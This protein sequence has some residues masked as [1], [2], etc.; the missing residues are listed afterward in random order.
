MLSSLN[1]PVLSNEI[2]FSRKQWEPL[3]GPIFFEYF[4]YQTYQEFAV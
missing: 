2:S 3:I 4:Y 1:Q